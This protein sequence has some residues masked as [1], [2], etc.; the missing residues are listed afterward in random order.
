MRS[1]PKTK[2]RRNTNMDRTTEQ[3][4]R[5]IGPCSHSSD[6]VKELAE[7][8]ANITPGL[9]LQPLK[10]RLQSLANDPS[11]DLPSSSLDL[12]REAG[13]GNEEIGS[14]VFA[15]QNLIPDAG[16]ESSLSREDTARFRQVAGLLAH[17]LRVYGEENALGWL[18]QPMRH[19]DRKSPL[20]F[21]IVTRNFDEVNGYLIE[22][23]E[24]YFF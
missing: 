5:K 3:S 16:S 15:D 23:S 10:V 19:F 9:A 4:I 8:K 14:L 20:E 6:R 2:M 1:Y 21:V 24:G 12:L 18:H 13:L 11:P 22:A 17:C 7:E